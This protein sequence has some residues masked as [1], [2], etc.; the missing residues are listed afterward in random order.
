MENILKDTIRTNE[1]KLEDVFFKIEHKE[2]LDLLENNELNIFCL[3]I[4]NNKF[5]YKELFNLLKDNLG[6][7]VL[8]RKEYQKNPERAISKAIDKLKIVQADS[9]DPGAGGEL[10]ELI[11][12]VFLEYY[13]HAPKILSK[14]ELKT[15]QNQ[16]VYNADGVHFYHFDKD[17]FSYYQLI[18]GE[19]KIKNNYSDAIDAAFNSIVTSKLNDTNEINLINSEIFKEVFSTE[20]MEQLKDMIV[21]K[22]TDDFNNN[23]IKNKAFGIFIG[24]DFK[25]DNTIPLLKQREKVKED[26]KELAKQVSQDIK[27]NVIKH[28][29]SG[30][31][32]YVY[33]LPFNNCLKDKSEVMRQ[34]LTQDSFKEV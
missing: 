9:N 31:S 8:S 27:S 22:V 18:I 33:F 4:V 19:S 17:D 5:S 10:G 26:L 13:L 16:Y 14:V 28:N 32:F 3:N 1:Q 24:F 30:Y 6:T 2:N 21:P 7:Y 20:E 25:I 12:Y 29:L 34:L 11:L 15:T 23:V